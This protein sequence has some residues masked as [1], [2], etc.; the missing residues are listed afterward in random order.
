M[1]KLKLV[2]DELEVQSFSTARGAPA[3]GT[4]HGRIT[5]DITCDQ[6]TCDYHNQTSCSPC[7]QQTYTCVS[8]CGAGGTQIDTCANTCN[9]CYPSHNEVNTCEYPFHSCNWDVCF[10]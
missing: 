8:D 1:N 9:P 5:E 3:R 2:L 4:V 6:F 10:G 7:E